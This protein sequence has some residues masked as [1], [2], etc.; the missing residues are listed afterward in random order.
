MPQ[1]LVPASAKPARSWPQRP[2]DRAVDAC[3]PTAGPPRRQAVIT[4]RG[5]AR[6]FKVLVT[7]AMQA[8]RALQSTDDSGSSIYRVEPPHVAQRLT[9]SA[10]AVVA[11][12][13]TAVYVTVIVQ[14]GNNSLREV[15]PWVVIMLIG[16]SAAAT[17]ALAPDHRVRRFCAIAATLIL[18]ALGVVAIFS[19]GVG[20]LLAAVIACLA[21]VSG[22]PDRQTSRRTTV[23]QLNSRVPTPDE[24]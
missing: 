17:S 23:G 21:A 18:G 1:A 24:H 7:Q 15:S 20:F 9:A 5:D 6:A 16:T 11:A 13:T 19:V 2:A 4:V 10:S 8:V 14:E 3:A 12:L 22:S